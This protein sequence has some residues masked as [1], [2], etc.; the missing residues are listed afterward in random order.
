MN[1]FC[2][3]MMRSTEER[4]RALEGLELSQE[5]L[6]SGVVDV[7]RYEDRYIWMVG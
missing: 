5:Q 7:Q 1:T 2:V 3:N 4:K 6:R